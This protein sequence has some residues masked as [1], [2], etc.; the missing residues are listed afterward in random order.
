LD[1]RCHF[2]HYRNY[3]NYLIVLMMMVADYRCH[4]VQ[5]KDLTG[6]M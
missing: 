6:W 5:L 2:L 4:S 3:R 1:C